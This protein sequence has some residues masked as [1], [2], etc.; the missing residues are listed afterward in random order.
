MRVPL[1]QIHRKALGVVLLWLAI[2]HATPSGS[3]ADDRD[4]Y[5]GMV[6][7][8]PRAGQIWGSPDMARSL[9]QLIDLGVGWVAIH[10]YA[11][12]LEDGTVSFRPALT[13]DYL[14]G[15]VQLSRQAGVKLFWKPHLAYWGSFAWRGA[16]EFGNDSRAWRRFFDSYQDFIVD[17]ARFAEKAGVELFAV[18]VE[19]EKTTQHDRRWR[20]I[21]A[22]VRQVFSGKITYAANWD[23]LDRVPFW[24]AVDL[25]GVHGYFPLVDSATQDREALARGWAEP[26]LQL[27]A[28]SRSL[29]DKPVLFAEIGYAR[30]ANAASEPWIPATSDAAEVRSLRRSLIE[31]ALERLE[32]APFVIGMF[33]WKWIPGDDSWDRDFSMKDSEARAALRARWGTDLTLTPTTAR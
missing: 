24:D 21:I 19:Y 32:A 11:R 23:G 7:S 14:H 3:L 1:I 15:A 22:A 28:L 18:G 2:P 5:R 31:V 8:C 16:I 27:E 4:F 9:E 26:L 12:L 25:I 33:W 17:Q 10:P 6:V 30:S 13:L 20:Q 29:G